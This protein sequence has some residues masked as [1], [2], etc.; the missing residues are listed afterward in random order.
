M[1]ICFVNSTKSG[2]FIDDED[3]HDKNRAVDYNSA[4]AGSQS[5]LQSEDE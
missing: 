3:S 1:G 2:W 5:V 4:V